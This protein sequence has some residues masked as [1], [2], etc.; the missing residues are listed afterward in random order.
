MADINFDCPLCNQNLDAPDDMGGDI[1]ECPACEEDIEIPSP[2][3][4]AQAGKKRIVI[5]KRPAARGTASSTRRP[6]PKTKAAP[7]AAPIA[8]PSET[9]TEDNVSEKSRTV[10]LLLCFF[11]GPLSVHRFYTG[12]IGTGILQILTA[13][14]FG[15]W[16]MIDF[17]MIICGNFKDKQGLP[18]QTW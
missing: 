8:E 14:G 1:I 15:I 10:A 3:P 13:G 2:K 4:P 6:S 11:F 9:A 16:L 18:L 7:Q 12:K 5:K 17:I